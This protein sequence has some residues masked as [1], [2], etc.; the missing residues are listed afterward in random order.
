MEKK[1]LVFVC[2]FVCLFVFIC[3]YKCHR[4][5]ERI[6]RITLFLSLI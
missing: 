5:L 2:L 3:S 1:M 4:E 6:G